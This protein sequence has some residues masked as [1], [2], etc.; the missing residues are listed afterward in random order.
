M[1]KE[2]LQAAVV[3]ALG[4]AAV[5][6]CPIQLPSNAIQQHNSGSNIAGTGSGSADDL[7]DAISSLQVLSTSYVNTFLSLLVMA[8]C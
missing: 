2:K 6:V 5:D 3:A 7:Q 1:I 4:E 8:A